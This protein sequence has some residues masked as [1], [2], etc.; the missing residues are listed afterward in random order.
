M[1]SQ[2]KFWNVEEAVTE[3]PGGV[4]FQV[5]PQNVVLCKVNLI[6]INK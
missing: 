2:K 6:S 3:F 1:D 5:L 4:I